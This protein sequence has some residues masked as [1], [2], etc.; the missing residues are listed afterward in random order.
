[1]KYLTP[2]IFMLIT[3]GA[4]ADVPQWMK[5]SEPN[6]LGL[7]SSIYGDCPFTNET[8]VKRIEGEFLRARIKANNDLSFNLTV[9]TLC[10]SINNKGGDNTGTA[11]SYEIRFGTQAPTGDFV[12]YENP[13]YGSMLID[14]KGPD[15]SQFFVTTITSSVEEALTD[16]LRANF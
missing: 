6:N 7:F 4:Y 5:R 3:G 1:M 14:G 8:L 11:V 13:N 10:M 12:L 9:N 15:S 16:Y 2:F